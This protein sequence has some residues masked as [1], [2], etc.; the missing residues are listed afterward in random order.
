ML[1]LSK[2][3]MSTK[4]IRT[5][6]EV[7]Q[8]TRS[9]LLYSKNSLDVG[10]QSTELSSLIRELKLILYGDDYSEPSAEA[11]AQLTVEFFKEDTLRLLIIFLPKLNLEARKDATQVVASLQR[12][13][14]PSRFEVSRYLEANLD[15][16]DIL[17]S[18]YTFYI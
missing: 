17:I 11:C 13:P 2:N 3:V 15:L 4:K 1:C 5:P 16:L 9:L 10:S 18:G 14:L 8:K 7:V 12:Q 6:S